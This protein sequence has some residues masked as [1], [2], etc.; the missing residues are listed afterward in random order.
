MKM[1]L[2]RGLILVFLL[3]FAIFASSVNAQ[4]FDTISNGMYW[5]VCNATS[6]AIQFG[7]LDNSS[8]YLSNFDRL[9]DSFLKDGYSW[10]FMPPE[11]LD[12]YFFI[13]TSYNPSST[14]CLDS[15]AC[16]FSNSITILELPGCNADQSCDYYGFFQFETGQGYEC[17]VCFDVD[18]K[19][20]GASGVNP[21]PTPPSGG[22]EIK[23]GSQSGFYLGNPF[24]TCGENQGWLCDSA[25]DFCKVPYAKISSINDETCC[26]DRETNGPPPP[27]PDPCVES[28]GDPNLFCVEDLGGDLIP[29]PDNQGS[30]IFCD[31]IISSFDTT[32]EF[33]CCKGAWGYTDN[34][35]SASPDNF[36]C[37]KEG[38]NSLFGECCWGTECLNY[39]ESV[40]G[41]IDGYQLFATG[42][43]LHT[44][45]SFNRL[46]QTEHDLNDRIIYKN[47]D[48]GNNY[49]SIDVTRSI[50]WSEFDTL[51]FDIKYLNNG[52]NNYPNQINLTLEDETTICTKNIQDGL[53]YDFLT[54]FQI[55]YYPPVAWHRVE[56]NLSN[57]NFNSNIKE[58]NV[59]FDSSLLGAMTVKLDNF[60]LSHST[61]L[62]LGPKY[63]SGLAGVWID[64]LNPDKPFEEVDYAN[65]SEWAP[66]SLPCDAQLSMGWTGRHCCGSNTTPDQA[67][68]YE[69][70]KAGCFG[71]V[72]VG[73]N[74]T[75]AQAMSFSLNDEI[76][77]RVLFYKNKFIGCNISSINSLASLGVSY[78]GETPSGILINDSVGFFEV[79]GSWYCMPSGWKRLVNANRMQILAATLK[80][81]GDDSNKDYSLHCGNYLDVLNA[82]ITNAPLSYVTDA[83]V[84]E[85][86][87]KN[88]TLG[89]VIGFDKLEEF[90]N[91]DL[92]TFFPFMYDNDSNYTC[93]GFSEF[94]STNFYQE[95][96][97]THN[98]L[99]VYYN[100]PFGI[101]LV[102]IQPSMA[103]TGFFGFLL[104]FWQAIIEFFK[105]LFG[106]D[107]PVPNAIAVPVSIDF[108]DYNELYINNVGSKT[109]KGVRQENTIVVEYIG[110]NNDVGFL[111]PLTKQWFLLYGIG[112]YN[113]TYKVSGT[114]Q[115]IGI[116]DTSS[117]NNFNW[118]YLTSNLKIK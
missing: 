107:M 16:C 60:F 112:D 99:A 89:F 71:G 96:V 63:C 46:T 85:I 88:V 49:V 22:F 79:K 100:K 21:N 44:V 59:L 106:A 92:K 32:N 6:D 86:D 68:Y 74:Q 91:D 54:K 13:D 20:I 31:N 101:M 26:Y 81:F 29:N 80:A 42:S 84:L 35:A 39:P 110:L 78:F 58:I 33:V 53:R 65:F 55:Q 114:S 109:I 103:P 83:C 61:D 111:E 18:G 50:S 17:P 115:F 28:T 73:P 57:C 10:C 47:A 34:F 5:Y 104:Q 11:P 7:D 72:F 23:G 87:N 14:D 105:N 93:S 67:E 70:Y 48:V 52:F 95:C 9:P 3:A 2:K 25:D 116:N 98:N 4:S 40:Y 75:A 38:G 62:S 113:V 76:F 8:H 108:A 117:V 45:V 102:Q 43:P 64:D 97:G 69:D 90:I 15:A 41:N 36:I 19:P 56:I 66:Y 94:N 82:N 27:Y 51:S 37:Y 30:N 12:S 77:S 1:R 118:N 24:R